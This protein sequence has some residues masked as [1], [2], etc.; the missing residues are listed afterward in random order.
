MINK[1]I[2][3]ENLREDQSSESC[4]SCLGFPWSDGRWPSTIRN[5]AA[6]QPKLFL[7]SLATEARLNTILTGR[8]LLLFLLFYPLD[9]TIGVFV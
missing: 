8:L 5:Q 1:I 6:S 2:G 9:E 7:T 3:I 4:K